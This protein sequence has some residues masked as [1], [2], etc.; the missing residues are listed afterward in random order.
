MSP[1]PYLTDTSAVVRV[2][3]DEDVRKAW[4]DH[5]AEGVVGICE[6]TELEIL[7][8]ARSLADRLEK[9]ALLGELFNWTP[10]PESVYVRARAVQRLL[11]GRGEH[12]SAGPVDL[13]VAA[14]AELTGLTLLH[15]DKDF[16]AIARATGQPTRWVARP[17]EA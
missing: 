11:T 14:T 5:L 10:V 6:V 2:L 13:L 17:G 15:C 9:E 7:F 16:D 1:V 4:R 3:T 8:S 12:R